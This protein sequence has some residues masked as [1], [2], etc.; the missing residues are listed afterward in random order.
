MGEDEPAVR[1]RHK[2]ERKELRKSCNANLNGLKGDDRKRAEAENK[3]LKEEQEKRHAEELANVLPV[4]KGDEEGETDNQGNAPSSTLN[5]APRQQDKKSKAQRRRERKE[6]RERERQKQI[7]EECAQA[8]PSMREI[9]TEHISS[10]LIDEGL[11]IHEVAADGHCLYRAVAHLLRTRGSHA[12]STLEQR[13]ASLSI[14]DQELSR[15]ILDFRHLRR[16]CAAYMRNRRSEFEPF[17]SLSD[18]KTYDAYCND[19]ENTAAW[20]GQPELRALSQVLQTPIVV[21]SAESP[22]VEMG[23]HFSNASLRVSFHRHY[24]ALGEHYNAVVDLP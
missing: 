3:A 6:E 10:R 9:E 17:L 21:H 13:L 18:G 24:F 8:G 1:K 2:A 20:G 16:V 4:K 14:A 15:G 5:M 12:A 22:D 11:Q 7:R 23:E 19:V